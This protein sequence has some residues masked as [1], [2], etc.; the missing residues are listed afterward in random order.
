MSLQRL[1]IPNVTFGT[2]TT[3]IPRKGL[4]LIATM[5]ISRGALLLAETALFSVSN[6]L[7]PFSRS[8]QRSISAQAPQFP[9]FQTLVSKADPP[10]DESR[11]ETN[12][13]DMGTDWNGGKTRGIFFQASRFNHS[14]VP[15][16]YF[17]W[18]P[19]L[20]K[21]QGLLTIY[22]IQDIDPYHEIL[23]NYRIDDWYK[24][25][26]ACQAG[27]NDAYGFLC[28]CVACQRQPGH[29]FG[30]KSDARRQRMQALKTQIDDRNWNLNTPRGRE[31]KRQNINKLIDNIR[32]EG[33]I[34][35]ALAEAL[36][37]LGK[38]AKDE[39]GVAKAA[40]AMSAAAYVRDC[41]EI[42][43]QIARE[44]LD[45]DVCCNGSQSP[46]VM[47]ALEFIWDLDD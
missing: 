11:F 44:K 21:G 19:E 7:E 42:A 30:A 36:D 14:C 38:L 5:H 1:H 8:N 22:A 43:L 33:L 6:V 16:A 2:T 41:R 26:D 29:Q 28:D 20:N 13:F 32:Q 17:V 15:N 18:N 40:N 10:T 27:L 9:Q 4:D 24:L 31:A 12:N 3:Q 35:P 34:C 25:K 37:E 45:L 39:L 46:V 47:A 23:V